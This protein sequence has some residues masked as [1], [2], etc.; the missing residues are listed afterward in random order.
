MAAAAR[1]ILAAILMV[2]F[3]LFIT[4]CGDVEEDAPT[5][6]SPAFDA[7][8][9]IGPDATPDTASD[10]EITYAEL[11]SECESRGLDCPVPDRLLSWQREKATN[12]GEAADE[13]CTE[14][15]ASCAEYQDV[16]DYIWTCFGM[17][18]GPYD[19]YYVDDHC[20]LMTEEWGPSGTYGAG[21]GPQPWI[22]HSPG[23]M[24]ITLCDPVEESEECW[25]LCTGTPKHSD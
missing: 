16:A 9:N 3:S 20:N 2:A 6:P 12:V 13:L 24:S 11:C 21:S 25:R 5:T 4:A 18:G 23:S 22:Y 17:S 8:Y 15:P 14:P 7:G 1:S 19:D 10:P